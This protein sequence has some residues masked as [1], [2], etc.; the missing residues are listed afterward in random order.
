MDKKRGLPQKKARSLNRKA[1]NW[2]TTA[3]RSQEWGKFRV[4]PVL[5]V[6]DRL[7]LKKRLKTQI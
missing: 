1:T 6:L 3:P 2:R 4:S 7:A 5:C